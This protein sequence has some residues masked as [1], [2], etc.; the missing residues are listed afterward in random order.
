MDRDA[1]VTWSTLQKQTGYRS[2]YVYKK[3]YTPR[4]ATAAHAQ[5]ITCEAQKKTE[6]KVGRMQDSYSDIEAEITKQRH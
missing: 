6:S 2:G 3:E 4:S 5:Q 1:R